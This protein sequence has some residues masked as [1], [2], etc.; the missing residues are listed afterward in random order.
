MTRTIAKDA[1][2]LVIKIGSALLTNN[3]A[4][5]DRAAIDGW[6]EQ[7]DQLLARAKKLFWSP[8]AQLPKA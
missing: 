1:K 4:G 5:L 2:R 8:P 7:I 3:G 6:V